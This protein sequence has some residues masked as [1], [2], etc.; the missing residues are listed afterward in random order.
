MHKRSEV[1]EK[2]LNWFVLENWQFDCI[3]SIKNSWLC[4]VYCLN[5]KRDNLLINWSINKYFKKLT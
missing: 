3:G 4:K 2:Y 1:G 5:I